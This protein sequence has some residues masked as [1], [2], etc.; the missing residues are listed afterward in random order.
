[1]NRPSALL[2]GVVLLAGCGSPAGS[3]PGSSP[4]TAIEAPSGSLALVSG[5]PTPF[6]A[7]TTT[8]VSSPA[9]LCA[10]GPADDTPD[11][12]LSTAADSGR[13]GLNSTIPGAE[14]D[15]WHQPDPTADVSVGAGARLTLTAL[16]DSAGRLCISTV[17]ADAVPFSSTGTQPATSMVQ[18][19][20]AEVAPAGAVTAS[21]IAP[22]ADGEWILRVVAGI[23][24]G[25][26][27][28]RQERRFWRLRIGVPEPAVGGKASRSGSCGSPAATAPHAL[29]TVGTAKPVAGEF[30]SMTWRGTAADAGDEPV[31][32]KVTMS[33]PSGLSIVLDDHICAGWWRIVIAPHPLDAGG[34]RLPLE[35]FADLVVP[36]IRVGGLAA[37]IANRFALDDLP[38]GDWVVRA[39]F[40][41]IDPTGSLVGHTTN[42]WNVVV[43]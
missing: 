27:S 29:L 40:D 22:K 39:S 16:S 8:A 21:I 25:A 38:A 10:P 15:S 30:G 2:F 24:S 28:M 6:P 26:G 1:M 17:A 34:F 18:A 32:A 11:L 23:P 35:P 42:Y 7:S 19:L 9:G 37:A 13:P 14:V 4:T 41:V 12:L 36:R 33:A 31:G 3:P 20:P 5:L 43:Q